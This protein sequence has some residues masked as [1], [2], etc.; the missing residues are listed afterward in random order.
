MQ[1][2]MAVKSAYDAY[3]KTND[4]KSLGDLK[5]STGQSYSSDFGYTVKTPAA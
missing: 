2:T 1:K 4:I 3:V 5:A